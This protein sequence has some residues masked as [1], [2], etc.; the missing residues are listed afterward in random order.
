LPTP[1]RLPFDIEVCG[2]E[3]IKDVAFKPIDH[4]FVAGVSKD[5]SYTNKELLDMFKI[6]N[7]EHCPIRE[8]K[9]MNLN[10]AKEMNVNFA[11]NILLKSA[12]NGTEDGLTIKNNFLVDT[13]F[14]FTL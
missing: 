9:L 11:K 4:G 6:T 12:V 1:T 7:S 8:L 13:E 2:L 14:S 10:S 5:F 3:D